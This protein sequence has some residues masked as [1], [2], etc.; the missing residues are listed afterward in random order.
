MQLSDYALPLATYFAEFL[1]TFFVV[2]TASLLALRDV[3]LVGSWAW[4]A[5]GVAFATVASISATSAVT[6]SHLNPAVS[7]AFGLARKMYW[8]R[9]W[10]Y[11]LVQESI[12]TS[13]LKLEDLGSRPSFYVFFLGQGVGEEVDCI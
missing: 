11:I 1:G 2:F 3:D 13:S 5:S 4:R 6:G 9:V 10:K 8:G 7:L 12:E